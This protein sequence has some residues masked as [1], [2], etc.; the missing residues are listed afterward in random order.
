MG[1]LDLLFSFK[2]RINRSQFWLGQIALIGLIAA[3][4]LIWVIGLAGTVGPDFS[5]LSQQQQNTATVSALSG[6]AFAFLFT[7]VLMC[8]IGAALAIKRL[9][10]R[11]KSGWTTMMY[12]V[13]GVVSVIAP[14]GI[15]LLLSTAVNIWVFIEL[16]FLK[17]DEGANQ[18]GPGPSGDVSAVVSREIAELELAAKSAAPSHQL[19]P[20]ANLP[21]KP[22]G[23]VKARAPRS[24]SAEKH[25]GFGRRSPRIA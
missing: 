9:H 2:G 23:V 22:S 14:L 18:F 15:F 10:D 1:V 4:F 8:W 5:T 13:P 24:S 3:V 20:A 19:A 17:G 21:G 12:A 6:L 7:T 11:G 16:G 25:A